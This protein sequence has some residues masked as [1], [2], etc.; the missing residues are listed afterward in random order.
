M[1]VHLVLRRRLPPASNGLS[2]TLSAHL[3]HP[4][5]PP[6]PRSTQNANNDCSGAT[7]AV[8]A[9]MF[10]DDCIVSGISSYSF[11]SCINATMVC[12]GGR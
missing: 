2:P 1:R 7:I 3:P 4:L 11:G 10:S 8:T 12:S 9:S 6:P 5:T